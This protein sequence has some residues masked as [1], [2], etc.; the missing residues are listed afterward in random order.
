MVMLKVALNRKALYNIAFII[1]SI[2]IISFSFILYK[3]YRR[4]QSINSYISFQYN[5]INK[6]NIILTDLLNMETGV[7][8][9][10]LTGEPSYLKPYTQA[11]AGLGRKLIGLRNLSYSESG[12]DRDILT[13]LDEIKA[14]E[15]LLSEQVALIEAQGIKSL[16]VRQIYEQRRIMDEIRGLLKISIDNRIEKLEAKLADA[17]AQRNSFLYI[18]LLG[19]LLIL[20]VLCLGNVTISRL[21]DRALKLSQDNEKAQDRFRYLMRGLNDGLFEYNF[22]NES[23]YLSKEYKALLGYD[24][25]EFDT[26]ISMQDIIHPDDREGAISERERY[27]KRETDTYSN[28]YRL[29]H[30]DG[31]YRWVLSRGVGIWDGAGHI[32][33]MIGT[34]RDITAEKK[35]EAELDQ[36]Y[37]D[38][39]AFTYIT[40]H[41]LRS[42]L[43]NMMG[44]SR[45]LLQSLSGISDI[46]GPHEQAI[47]DLLGTRDFAALTNL[48]DQDMPESLQ[49]ITGAVER[50]DRLTRAL[51]NLSRIGQHEQ[52]LSL[53][54][55]RLVLDK[56]LATQN[57][58]IT[59]K[60]VSYEIGP[61]PLMVT[62]HFSIEQIF[63]NLIDNAVK[64]L[65]PDRQGQLKFTCEDRGYD[66]LFRFSDNGRGI[67]PQDYERVTEIFRRARNA[68]DVPGQGMGMAFVKA[69]LRKLSGDM[70]FE[71]ELGQGTTFFISLPQLKPLVADTQSQATAPYLS[72]APTASAQTLRISP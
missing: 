24:E 69:T 21:E 9:Y 31:S 72:P 46:L 67:A 43:I 37:K 15:A 6:S 39:E 11:N 44:F 50:M 26:Y 22:I 14:L 57:Y 42:P 19:N 59:R 30:K 61:M 70:W 48:I 35:R 10:M 65:E 62:D 64:Y 33:T 7:R 18:M 56:C 53:V 16:S 5:V 40:S 68:I 55:T 66:Y 41:D 34:Q 12:T 1:I 2:V 52:S 27:I 63:S 25:H 8:G 60:S 17:N 71:S 28:S 32:K 49:F 47:R 29:R 3:Q 36:L 45:E 58:E 51:L 23:L 54:D 20:L 13:W 38:M 4:I